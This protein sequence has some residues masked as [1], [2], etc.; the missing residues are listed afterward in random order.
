MNRGPSGTTNLNSGKHHFP[1]KES[2]FARIMR[3]ARPYWLHLLGVFLLSM[4]ATPISLLVPLPLK[5]AVDSAIGSHPLPPLLAA[6]MP[7]SA[8]RSSTAIMALAVALLIAVSLLSQL[9]DL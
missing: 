8:V 6:L 9:Q 5:I 3:Q 7:E 1:T 2:L 4:L